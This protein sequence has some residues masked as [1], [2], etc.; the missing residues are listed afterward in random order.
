MIDPSHKDPALHEPL[1]SKCRAL[2]LRSQSPVAFPE[3]DA[4]LEV[5]SCLVG[6]VGCRWCDV[7]V[8]R[9]L[10]VRYIAVCC[11]VFLA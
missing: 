5:C 2:A 10:M 7:D 11:A 6:M 3:L 4:R 1:H 9:S 8:D